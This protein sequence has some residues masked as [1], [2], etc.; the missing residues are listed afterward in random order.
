MRT[1]LALALMGTAFANTDAENAV[2]DALDQA[3]DAVADDLN[4]VGERNWVEVIANHWSANYYTECV[5]L[6]NVC[7]WHFNYTW[8]ATHI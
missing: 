2:A 8:T 3:K 7:T 6:T 4:R 1:T 5:N